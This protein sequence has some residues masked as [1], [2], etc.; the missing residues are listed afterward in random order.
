MDQRNTEIKF[1]NTYRVGTYL[2]LFTN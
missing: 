1:A 2:K